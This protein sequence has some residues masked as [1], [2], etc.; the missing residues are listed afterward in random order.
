MADAERRPTRHDRRKALTRARIIDAANRLFA[1]KGYLETSVEDIAE[2]A[3]VAARTVYMHFPAKASILL[4]HFDRWLDAL[5][6]GILDRSVREPIAV[7]VSAA[8]DAMAADGWVN[9]SYGDI[10]ASPPSALG[11]VVGPPEIAGYMMQAWLSA[12]Q[13][14]V[15]DAFARGGYP[16][17]SLVPHAR[18]A[19]VFAACMGP[20][21][22]ARIS[23]S[24]EPLPRDATANGLITRFL[25]DLTRG[26]L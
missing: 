13:R 14:L 22:A 16:D 26:G 19:A 23:L 8:L 25:T 20:I 3:D 7:T 1:D 24:G 21:S 17:D 5:V 2:E 11:L 12:Q 9:R 10:A 4:D 18:A 6:R 15:D